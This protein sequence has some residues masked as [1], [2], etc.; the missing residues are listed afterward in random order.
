MYPQSANATQLAL[1]LSL[2][3]LR[4]V[5]GLS[6]LTEQVMDNK[7]GNLKSSSFIHFGSCTSAVAR[8]TCRCYV[9]ERESKLKGLSLPFLQCKRKRLI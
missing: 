5:R 3:I 6:L 8:M 1:R 4:P 7:A 2:R 9:L